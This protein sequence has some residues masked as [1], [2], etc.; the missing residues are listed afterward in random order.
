VKNNW[1]KLFFISLFVAGVLSVF[2]SKSP[3]GLNRVAERFGF[4]ERGYF[5]HGI[6]AGYSFPA[7]ENS[8]VSTSLS[9]IVGVCLVFGILFVF[10]RIIFQVSIKE[11]GDPEKT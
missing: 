7:L 8:F 3:D 9:G 1:K 2:G 11:K 4:A 6:L 10:G 5:S